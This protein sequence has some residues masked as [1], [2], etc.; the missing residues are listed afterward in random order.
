MKLK[1]KTIEKIFRTIDFSKG[2]CYIYTMIMM[3]R[4]NTNLN[5]PYYLIEVCGHLC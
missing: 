1:F 2:N 5:K 4:Q 3:D